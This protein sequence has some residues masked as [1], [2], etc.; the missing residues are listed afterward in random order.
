MTYDS[1]NDVLYGLDAIGTTMYTIDRVTG[2]WTGIASTGAVTPVA[3]AYEPT[4]DA[5]FGVDSF[6]D[7]LSSVDR[8]TA[9][10]TTIGATGVTSPAG[11]AFA[12]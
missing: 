11:L 4:A 6:S 7:E 10:W 9:A 5:M 12:L 1:V 2:A 3:L 8:G